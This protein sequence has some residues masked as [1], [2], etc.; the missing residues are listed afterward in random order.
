[1]NKLDIV[2]TRLTAFKM[3]IMLFKKR[4]ALS[5]GGIYKSF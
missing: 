5:L 1:M 2:Y 4:T 3:L